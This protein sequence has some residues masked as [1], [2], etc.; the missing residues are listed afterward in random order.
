MKWLLLH[1]NKINEVIEGLPEEFG[2]LEQALLVLL[3]KELN[4]LFVPS[5]L[6]PSYEHLLSQMTR[7]YLHPQKFIGVGYFGFTIQMENG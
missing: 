1:L 4:S 7:L 5:F 2:L 6:S 3:E